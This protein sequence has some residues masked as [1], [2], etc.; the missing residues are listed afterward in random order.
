MN[1][2]STESV[3]Q[4][5]N[6]TQSKIRVKTNVIPFTNVKPLSQ[7]ELAQ[8]WQ[9]VVPRVKRIKKEQKDELGN[10]T[11]KVS[12]NIYR[13]KINLAQ[14]PLHLWCR[15][16]RNNNKI[17]D[18]SHHY[19]VEATPVD[20]DIITLVNILKQP[21]SEQYTTRVHSIL[22]TLKENDIYGW[23]IIRATELYT[24]N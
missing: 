12:S 1:N 20:D 9:L 15:L 3:E 17:V 5:T 2:N 23:A 22:E 14:L 16:N 18:K 6:A 19:F 11:V 8:G 7:N 13:S 4:S 10:A 21:Y 24:Q